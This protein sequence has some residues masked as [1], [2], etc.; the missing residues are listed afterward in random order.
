MMKIEVQA[1]NTSEEITYPCLLKEKTCSL[2]IFAPEKESNAIVMVGNEHWRQGAYYDD[3]NE[4]KYEL[5][6]G[7]ITLSN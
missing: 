1:D 5:F 3:F 6:R 4:E 7:S 2:V